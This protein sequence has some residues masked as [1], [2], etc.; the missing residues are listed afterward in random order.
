MG[1]DKKTLAWV[2]HLAV[3][4]KLLGTLLAAKEHEAVQLVSIVGINRICRCM[5]LPCEIK[6][7]VFKFP[8]KSPCF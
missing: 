1:R 6:T 4:V 8:S 5:M 7:G 2:Q 3:K